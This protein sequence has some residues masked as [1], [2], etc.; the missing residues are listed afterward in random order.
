MDV[1]EP[2]LDAARAV[3]VRRGYA[4]TTMQ[5]VA[6]AAGV[7]PGVVKSLYDNKDQ[8][9]SAAMR[10]PMD[11]QHAVPNLIAPGLDGMGERIVRMTLAMMSE[12]RVRSDM[13]QV[14]NDSGNFERMIRQLAGLL[15]LPVIDTVVTAL[16]IPDARMRGSLITAQ[17]AGLAGTRYVMKLQPLAGASDDEV[18]A[19]YG[20]IIQALLDPTI[21]LPGSSPTGKPGSR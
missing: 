14:A 7:A 11:P 15:Q 16:G 8:L 17:L 9:F 19:I 12:D 3:F 10:A 13:T 4:G 18:V 20:P 2:I 6:V 1:R 5:A 21:P